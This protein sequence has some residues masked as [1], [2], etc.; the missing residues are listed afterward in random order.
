MTAWSS[1]GDRRAEPLLKFYRQGKSCRDDPMRMRHDALAAAAEWI[2]SVERIAL[3]G[4]KLAWSLRS[5]SIHAMP[6]AR[7]VIAGDVAATVDVRHADDAVRGAALE[8]ILLR[9]AAGGG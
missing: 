9:G 1:G 8:R 6:G 5:G 3:R 4:R 2:V 7:N